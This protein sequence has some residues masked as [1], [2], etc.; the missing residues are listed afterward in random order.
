[1]SNNRET[2]ISKE[3]VSKD[4]P[5]MWAICSC[6]VS[7][8]TVRAENV[9]P[10]LENSVSFFERTIIS[11]DDQIWIHCTSI[12]DQE[13]VEKIKDMKRGSMILDVIHLSPFP[14]NFASTFE[15]SEYK[16]HHVVFVVKDRLRGDWITIYRPPKQYNDFKR[17]LNDYFLNK[18]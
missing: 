17:Y 11:D 7:G 5:W 1:M 13:W 9:I 8:M 16:I 12:Y 4:F 14:K 3:R 10:K 18:V 15:E 2:S 6:W